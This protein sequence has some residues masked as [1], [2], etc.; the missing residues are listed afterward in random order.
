MIKIH[1]GLD[2]LPKFKDAVVTIGTFDGVHLGHQ[3]IISQMVAEARASGGETVIVTFHPH[4]RTVVGGFVDGILTTMD[5]KIHLLGKS[6]I[7]HLIVVPFT[8]SFSRMSAEQY[9]RDFLYAKFSP[10]TIIIGYDHRFGE[11]RQGS[12]Q[13]LEKAGA[14]LGFAVK[15]IDPLVIETI[16]IGSTKIREAL[17]SQHIELANR[18]LG[19]P[20]SFTGTV[21]KG[22]QLGRTIG[23]PTANLAINDANKLLPENGSYVVKAFL[24]DGNGND[25]EA[26]GGMMNIGYRPTVDGSKMAVEVHLFDFD[27]DIYGRQLRVETLYFLRNEE[28]FNGKEALITQLG[29]DKATA[30]E[31]LSAS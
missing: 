20:Y 30:R 18:L 27:M 16:T 17:R 22:N 25:G 11:G 15:E 28:K 7:D 8:A 26:I 29:L 21:V 23:Y 13:T 4:P 5:E 6:G 12:Y 14:E 2:N 31:R 1:R 9:C 24:M 3:K 10:V 19:Y